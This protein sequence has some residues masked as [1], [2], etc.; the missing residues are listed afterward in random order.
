MYT[1]RGD[2]V[3]VLIGIIKDFTVELFFPNRSLSLDIILQPFG[4]PLPT[5]WLRIEVLP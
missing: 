5:G 3:T 4:H 2:I 1:Y